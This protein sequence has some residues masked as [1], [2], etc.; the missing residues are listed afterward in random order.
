YDGRMRIDAS[1]PN[2]D[3][4]DFARRFQMRS[5]SLM[6]LLGAGAS[7]SSG[8]P[9]A[10]EMLWEFKQALYVSQKKVSLKS[11]EDLTNPAIRSLIQ[12]YISSSTSFPAEGAPDEYAVIFEAAWPN[13]GDRR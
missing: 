10:G 3:V 1:V 11:V 12:N 8:I 9:T 5:G 4:D 13:E 7:A 2:V 6:W